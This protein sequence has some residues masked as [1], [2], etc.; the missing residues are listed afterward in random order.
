MYQMVMEA[1][2][3]A[4]RGRGF[5]SLF[6][7]WACLPTSPSLHPSSPPQ[8]GKEGRDA[9]GE[10]RSA[11]PQPVSLASITVACPACT[12]APSLSRALALSSSLALLCSM[13]S[14]VGGGGPS[15]STSRILHP[16]SSPPSPSFLIPFSHAEATRRSRRTDAT[17]ERGWEFARA[18]EA[19][20]SE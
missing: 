2:V 18:R 5:P 8:R 12:L 17:A 14:F 3:L 11:M 7:F 20:E 4:R 16:P 13:R 1:S 6:Y 19:S 9:E 10:G 15:G